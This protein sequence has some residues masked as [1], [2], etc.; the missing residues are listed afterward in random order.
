MAGEPITS[1]RH[2]FGSSKISGCIRVAAVLSVAFAIGTSPAAATPVAANDTTE[3]RRWAEHTRV[4]F[5]MWSTHLDDIGEGLSS[6]YLIGLAWRG[7]FGVTFIN[8]FGDRS[9]AVGLQRSFSP[10]RDRPVTAALGYR[11][12]LITGYD[13]RFFGIGDKLPALPFAQLMGTL[14]FGRFGIELNYSGIVAA[15]VLNWRP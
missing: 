8:S 15:F 9:F 12:G 1:S 10:G 3:A 14:N 6:N 5:G 13:E 11:A 4:F 7:Y 2:P